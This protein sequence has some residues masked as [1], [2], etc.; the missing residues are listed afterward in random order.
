[1]IEFL[2]HRDRDANAAVIE[3]QGKRIFSKAGDWSHWIRLDFQLSTPWYML[4]QKVNGVCRFYLQ[5]VAPNFRLFVT[6]INIDPGNPA[7]KISEPSSFIQEVVRAAR[8]V[9]HHRLSRSL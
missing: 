1:M 6:P 3:I 9:R 4:S 7:V 5:E 2:V 8:P